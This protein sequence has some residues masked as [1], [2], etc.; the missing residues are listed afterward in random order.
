MD[1]KPCQGCVDREWAAQIWLCVEGN[2]C[3]ELK[4]RDA[5]K[6]WLT[7]TMQKQSESMSAVLTSVWFSLHSRASDVT[8][9]SFKFCLD[10]IGLPVSCS[11]TWLLVTATH[12]QFPLISG[13]LNP[14]RV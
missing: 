5:R 11:L 14:F 4:C 9:A 7:G 10:G 12:L 13:P 3:T 8:L 2:C 6:H 1:E